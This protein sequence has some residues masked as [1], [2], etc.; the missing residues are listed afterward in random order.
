[1]QDCQLLETGENEIPRRLVMSEISW[2]TTT[3][4]ERDHWYT[5]HPASPLFAKNTPTLQEMM[6]PVP[7]YCMPGIPSFQMF[8]VPGILRRHFVQIINRP[9]K[10]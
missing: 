7:H 2:E 5:E 3:D 4:M 1:M 9:M 6:L 8:Q 10:N